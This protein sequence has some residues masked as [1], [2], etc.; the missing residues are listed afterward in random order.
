M[1][2][3]LRAS[4]DDRLSGSGAAEGQGGDQAADQ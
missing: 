4:D 2:L 1:A 3:I